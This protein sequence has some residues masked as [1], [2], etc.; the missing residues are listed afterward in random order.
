MIGE[1]TSHL[2]GD[3]SEQ[4]VNGGGGSKAEVKWKWR[5]GNRSNN[6]GKGFSLLLSQKT[7]V[8]TDGWG[9]PWQSSH[10]DS[11]IVKIIGSGYKGKK[12]IL[13]FFSNFIFSLCQS[14][15]AIT[16]ISHH[17]LWVQQKLGQANYKLSHKNIHTTSHSWRVNTVLS[18]SP[19]NKSTPNS[20]CFISRC[21]KK[22]TFDDRGCH[23]K[24]IWTPWVQTILL[25]V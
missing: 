7:R 19:W 9:R 12:W 8:T 5:L 22:T 20:W 17:V 13:V 3:W 23:L 21:K 25:W 11:Y 4:V 15:S 24:F 2:K 16:A 14:H 10:T 1:Q 18:R 6:S